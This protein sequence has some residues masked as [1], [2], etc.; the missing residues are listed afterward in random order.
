MAKETKADSILAALS[1][2]FPEDRIEWR[3]GRSWNKEGKI[4]ATCLA[5]IDSRAGYDRLDEVVG[6]EN[7]KDEYEFIPGNPGGVLCRLSIRIGVEWITK[8]DGASATHFEGFKGGISAAFKRAAS[9]WGVGRYLYGLEEGFVTVAINK[10][11]GAFYQAK[12]EKCP[13]FYWFP[14]GLPNWALPKGSPKVQEQRN[15]KT[16]EKDSCPSQIPNSGEL[17]LATHDQSRLIWALSKKNNYTE[18]GLKDLMFSLFGATVCTKDGIP[19]MK[20]VTRKQASELIKIFEDEDKKFRND[21][22]IPF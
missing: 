13:S 6:C 20:K 2:P 8:V 11:K 5:Y 21:E 12:S 9:K 17:D 1:E 18:E 14:P 10:E 7:W 22:K 15:S 19:T 4:G 3:I 16:A